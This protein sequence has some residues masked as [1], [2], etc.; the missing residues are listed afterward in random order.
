M[1]TEARA[2]AIADRLSAVVLT[3]PRSA[4]AMACMN[5]PP[6]ATPL[7]VGSRSH[8]GCLGGGVCHG[9][10]S[11]GGVID[12]RGVVDPGGWSTQVGWSTRWVAPRWVHPLPFSPLAPTLAKTYATILERRNRG[13]AKGQRKQPLAAPAMAPPSTSDHSRRRRSSWLEAC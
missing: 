7:Q 1:N 4:G 6:F 13:P 9:R 2:R 3:T 8:R 12:P 11:P 5:L 10:V